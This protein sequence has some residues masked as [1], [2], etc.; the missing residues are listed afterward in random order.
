MKHILLFACALL[1]GSLAYAQ[2][3]GQAPAGSTPPTFPTDTK[4]NGTSSNAPQADA[5]QPTSGEV[6][7]QINQKLAQE[8]G[9]KNTDVRFDVDD[10][11][12]VVSGTVNDEQQHQAALRLAQSFAGNR[13]I[14]DYVKLRSGK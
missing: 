7:Q 13:K 1:L 5:S 6:Q 14:T 8:P 2:Q 4:P 12:I 10:T 3:P 9:L 11:A